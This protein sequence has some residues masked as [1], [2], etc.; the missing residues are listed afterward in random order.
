VAIK[1]KEKDETQ[2]VSQIQGAAVGVGAGRKVET[3]MFAGA[4]NIRGNGK[5]SRL[6]G[7]W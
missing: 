7:Q 2:P 4:R 3:G 6:L 1:K 5:F